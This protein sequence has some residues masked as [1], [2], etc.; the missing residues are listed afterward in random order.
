MLPTSLYAQTTHKVAIEIINRSED[1][2]GT[3]L[4]FQIK[5][6]IKG[7]NIFRQAKA[8]EPRL[9]LI[10]NSIDQDADNPGASTVYSVIWTFANADESPAMLNNTLG[11]CGSE[12]VANAAETI[13]A[14]TD[15]IVEILRK[16]NKEPIKK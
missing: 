6:K 8:S 10:I 3:R 12:R 14:E 4:V 15:K 11:V 2:V 1:P 9:Q 13:L 16:V 5:E 7:S